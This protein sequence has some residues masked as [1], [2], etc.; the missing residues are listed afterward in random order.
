MKN[1]NDEMVL[2]IEGYDYEKNED[3]LVSIESFIDDFQKNK[4][5]GELLVSVKDGLIQSVIQNTSVKIKNR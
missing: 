1:K 2:T 4:S 5:S 3:A